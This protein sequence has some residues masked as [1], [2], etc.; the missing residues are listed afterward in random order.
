MNVGHHQREDWRSHH[1]SSTN[2]TTAV[3]FSHK[4]Q[5]VEQEKGRWK[6]H[7]HVFPLREVKQRPATSFFL[8]LWEILRNLNIAC[9]LR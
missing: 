9:R 3:G 7:L 5:T 2:T 1:S 4:T 6:N 8:G